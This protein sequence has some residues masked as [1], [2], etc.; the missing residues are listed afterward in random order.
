MQSKPISAQTAHVPRDWRRVKTSNVNVTIRDTR[1]AQMVIAE[2]IAK[3]L[4]I[5]AALWMHLCYVHK[6]NASS[7][8]T[9][10]QE[11]IIAIYQL[12]FFALI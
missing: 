9:N 3:L 10:A 2:E 12:L 11:V 4:D 7:I 1:D 6:E 5:R 8:S